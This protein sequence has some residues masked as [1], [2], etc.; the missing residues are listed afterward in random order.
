MQNNKSIS[1]VGGASA[2]ARGLF[3]RRAPGQSWLPAVMALAPLVFFAGCV[4]KQKAQM[5]ARQAY[6]AGQQQASQATA[7]TLA[8][9]VQGQVRNHLI[10]WTI[11]L[12]LARA[13]V[14]ANYMGGFKP[15]II[16]VIRNR[17][18]IEVDPND[19]LKGQDMPM[20]AGDAVQIVN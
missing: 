20:E 19:L 6:M 9:S 4:S 17:Q 16:R 11:D 2:K 1:G 18:T 10:P 5:E 3:G 7:N 13:I 8:V 15:K 14:A 12:T